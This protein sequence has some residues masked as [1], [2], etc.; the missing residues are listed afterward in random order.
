MAL[1]K[2]CE[3]DPALRGSFC[4]NCALEL[5]IRC[6]CGKDMSDEERISGMC[7]RCANYAGLGKVVGQEFD[8]ANAIDRAAAKIKAKRQQQRQAM[9]A[10]FNPRRTRADAGWYVQ[11]RDTRTGRVYDV[12]D[13]QGTRKATCTRRPDAWGMLDE[14]LEI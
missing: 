6:H 2:N 13:A 5:P 12:L 1:C 10:N 14:E 7:A 11:S 4:A 9:H 8:G 3:T